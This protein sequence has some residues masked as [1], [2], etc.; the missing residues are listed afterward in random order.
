VTVTAVETGQSQWAVIWRQFRRRRLAVVCA[1]VIVLLATI[2][3]FAPFLANDRP[4]YYRGVNRFEFR[5]A[6]RTLRE[7]VKRLS[8]AQTGEL[9]AKAR[10]DLVKSVQLQLR[11]MRPSLPVDA[12]PKLDELRGRLMSAIESSDA[13]N[14]RTLRTT[15]QA[16]YGRRDLSLASRAFSP[17]LASLHW[18]DL[19][20][21][22][23]NVVLLAAPVWY[24][25][26]GRWVPAHKPHRRNRIASLIGFGIPVATALIW[27]SLVPARIDQTNYKAGVLAADESA[28]TAL[29]V[30]ESVL[31]PPIPFG[32]DEGDLSRKLAKPAAFAKDDPDAKPSSPWNGPHW[33]GTNSLGRD[34]LCRMIWG[35]R[36]SLSVGIVAVAIYVSIGI[37]VGAIAGYFRGV[38]DLV[39]SR[40]IEV[41]ICFPAFF[42]ILT[43]VAFLGPGIMNIMIVIGLTGWT[44]IA[45]LIRGEFL[46]LVDQEFVLAGRA[47]GYSPARLIFKH[48]LPNAM[49]PVLV[50]AT[51]GVA[52]A[53]LTESALSFLGLGITPPMPS[54]GEMLSSGRDAMFHAPWLIWYPGLAIFVTI[55]SYNLVGEALRDASDPRL[56]GSR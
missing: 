28:S 2:S 39:I 30:Y 50:S 40:I 12:Q 44:G 7:V 48:I 33:L 36:V 26:L 37:V 29:V 24:R 15:I 13:A 32:L 53:I 47:L 54:W 14:L 38:W 46:R 51:F 20:F 52:G 17:I 4:L 1:G 8:D 49:A 6:V 56:R 42:L 27:A 43:I 9:L 10:S 3:I 22:T 16:E 34:V 25:A 23:G 19:L 18:G 35:G 11:L 41:V 45:R 5:E 31:W 21:M 55:S